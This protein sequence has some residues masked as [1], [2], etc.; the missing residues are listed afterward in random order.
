MPL[1]PTQLFL[2]PVPAIL[3]MQEMENP[4]VTLMNV[5]RCQMDVQ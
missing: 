3:V 1:V 5:M 2:I 4:V